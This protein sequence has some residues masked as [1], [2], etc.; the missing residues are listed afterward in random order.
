MNKELE[1]QRLEE[2]ML[3]EF[4]A[5]YGEQLHVDPAESTPDA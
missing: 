2:Q 4:W 3:D 5:S 1:Q